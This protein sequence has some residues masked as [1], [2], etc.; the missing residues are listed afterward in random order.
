MFESVFEKTITIAKS[1]TSVSDVVE[2]IKKIVEQCT[3]IDLK[4]A[5][6]EVI[7]RTKYSNN[8]SLQKCDS[9]LHLALEMAVRSTDVNVTMEGKKLYSEDEDIKRK[10]K[11]VEENVYNSCYK[12]K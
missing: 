12:R 3:D 11:E 4:S 9:I 8:I 1:V 2:D 5:L 10:I 6:K 7:D